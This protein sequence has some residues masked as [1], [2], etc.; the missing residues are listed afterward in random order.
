MWVHIS[1]VFLSDFTV[2][3]VPC[4]L[5]WAMLAIPNKLL[6]D[7]HSEHIHSLGSHSATGVWVHI[8]SVSNKQCKRMTA[9]LLSGTFKNK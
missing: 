8:S 4:I 2:D 9:I 5:C 6:L 7:S 3:F 1:S